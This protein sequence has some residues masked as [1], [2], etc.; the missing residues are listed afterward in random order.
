MIKKVTI[1][2]FALVVWAGLAGCSGE[3]GSSAE[4]AIGS[5]DLSTSGMA[6]KWM[7]PEEMAEQLGFTEEQKASMKAI[8]EKFA[9]QRQEIWA[10]IDKSATRE[11]R[12]AAMKN[13]H[14]RIKTEMN[15]VLTQEQMAELRELRSEHRKSREANRSFEAGER[16]ENRVMFLTEKLDLS[17]E[18]QAALKTALTEVSGA[19][20]PEPGAG[21]NH[22]AMIEMRNQMH[23][24]L[25]GILTAEQFEQFEQMKNERG[26]RFRGAKPQTL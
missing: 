10:G 11:E 8:H 15:A 19:F 5:I 18:Q 26:R 12:R 22:E 17:T 14:E 7:S 23:E 21:L 20:R 4:S 2:G 13:F 6:V 1:L 16:I 3:S 9:D 25:R 24:A